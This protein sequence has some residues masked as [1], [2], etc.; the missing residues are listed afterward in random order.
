MKSPYISDLQPDE[1]ATG[2]FLVQ[3]KDIRQKKSGEPYL[4]L[5][6]GDRTGDVEA[7]MFDNAAEVMDT[8]DRGAFVRCQGA[9]PD[10][11]EPAA[12]HAAQASA[13]RGFRSRPL[14]FL[15]ASKR[16]RD[17]MFLELRGWI[18]GVAIPHLKALLEII[19]ADPKSRSPIAPLPP[20]KPCITPGSAD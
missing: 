17:E 7:K 20:R 6:L 13:G 11:P 9:A 15:P 18:A 3:H 10:F 16:D 1:V 2:I 12:V 4:S 14:G 5:I 8:F 19:F